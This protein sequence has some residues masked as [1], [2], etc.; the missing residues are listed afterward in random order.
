MRNVPDKICREKSKRTFYIKFFFCFENRAVYEIK[1]KNIA[2]PDR[3][4]MTWR[5]REQCCITKT[6][7]THSEYVI[8]LA[9]AL[10]QWLHERASLLRHTYSACLVVNKCV[11]CA[12]GA[13]FLFI[14]CNV[15]NAS[16]VTTSSRNVTIHDSRC[17]NTTER[18]ALSD[19]TQ[20]H[21]HT[22]AVFTYSAPSEFLQHA[23]KRGFRDTAGRLQCGILQ[24]VLGKV[25]RM[26]WLCR[27][28]VPDAVM[29]QRQ[30]S[31]PQLVHPE[32]HPNEVKAHFIL[33]TCND[34]QTQI[35]DVRTGGTH[36]YHCALS[37][38][39]NFCI[40]VSTRNVASP[41]YAPPP[42]SLSA[43]TTQGSGSALQTGLSGSHILLFEWVPAL[44][45]CG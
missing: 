40:C 24:E 39:S 19:S 4:Q 45:P 22:A 15:W 36:S 14:T 16:G 10:Q 37:L 28:A 29:T 8:L 5:I 11:Y 12:L 7:D 25:L 21:R 2:E 35:F 42:T 33:F 26:A 34:G 13:R 23:K 31:L 30:S 43:C 20:F 32:V 44:C 38:V 27:N 41:V 6:T 18:T 3:P 9:F 1:R 17:R